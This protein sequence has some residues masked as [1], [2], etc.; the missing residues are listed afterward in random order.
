ML[1]KQ[2]KEDQ[3]AIDGES[4]RKNQGVISQQSRRAKIQAG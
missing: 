3:Q 4:N 2:K 1:S